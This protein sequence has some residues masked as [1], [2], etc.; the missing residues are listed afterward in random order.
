MADLANLGENGHEAFR[1]AGWGIAA[2]FLL[3][4]LVGVGFAPLCLGFGGV[5]L[6]LGC[7]KGVE[8]HGNHSC[9]L[10]LTGVGDDI[11]Q[12]LPLQFQQLNLLG[13]ALTF[14]ELPF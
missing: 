9:F 1:G 8:I 12:L 5:T 6:L 13:Q 2:G 4:F 10:N 3:K 11:I 7:V 14:P